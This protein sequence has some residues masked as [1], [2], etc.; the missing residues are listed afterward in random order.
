MKKERIAWILGGASGLGLELTKTALRHSDI[1]PLTVGRT[2]I[3]DTKQ[4]GIETHTPHIYIDLL[5]RNTVDAL[6]QN[7]TIM[8]IH[9]V[10]WFVWN[11]AIFERKPIDQTEKLDDIINANIHHPT[12][13]LRAFIGR[14]KI[15]HSAFHL[16][17]IAST[18]SFRAHTDEQVYCGSKA[19]Q[20][21]FSHAIALELKRDLPGSKVTIVNP[22]GMK[23]N[24][25]EGTNTDTTCFMNPREVA[26]MIWSSLLGQVEEVDEIQIERDEAGKVM[27]TREKNRGG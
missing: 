5:N 15:L 12:K 24:F 16:V 2:P 1:C 6:C 11:A 18:S 17:T 23:T 22:S 26:E 25:F 8:D 3:R 21:Q 4:S 13:I 19:Y 9:D 27:I 10:A 14:K 7:I 20:V